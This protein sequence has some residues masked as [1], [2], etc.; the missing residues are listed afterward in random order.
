MRKEEIRTEKLFA[1]VSYP[2]GK[3]LKVY[4][5]ISAD[6]LKK[7]A[8]MVEQDRFAFSNIAQAISA[9]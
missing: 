3:M 4:Q 8:K 6:E 1:S 2:D 5:V 9:N 7:L